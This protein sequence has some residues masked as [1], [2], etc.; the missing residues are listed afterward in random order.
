MSYLFHKLRF[1]SLCLLA[2]GLLPHAANAQDINE[3]KAA[4]SYNFAKFTQW[5]EK[6]QA[7]ESW[8]FCYIG[9]QYRT[10]FELFNNKKL[11]DKLISISELTDLKD[12]NK[13]HLVYIGAD[14]RKL[15][16]RL[17][18]AV[19]KRPILTISDMSGFI[20]MQG[21]IEITP[22]DNR[23]QFKVNLSQIQK[24]QLKLSSQVLKLAIEVKR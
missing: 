15:L 3:L 1:I 7:K 2:V 11:A 14:N 5:P 23:L 17:F 8:Q 9:E 24:S 13:C 20:D 16:P 19:D 6:A 4:L 22:S 12:I 10:G 18:L 21:M